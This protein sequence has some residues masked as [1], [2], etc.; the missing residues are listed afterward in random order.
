MR[1][2]KPKKPRSDWAKNI[3]PMDEPGTFIGNKFNGNPVFVEPKYPG[4]NKI[5]LGGIKNGE[6]N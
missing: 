4:R 2:N 3:P 5:I 1:K 6:R